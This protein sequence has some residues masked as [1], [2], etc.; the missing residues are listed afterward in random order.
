MVSSDSKNIFLLLFERAGSVSTAPSELLRV[1]GKRLQV[2]VC[3]FEVQELSGVEKVGYGA[4]KSKLHM[5]L[6][7]IVFVW[8]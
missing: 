5:E 3:C 1:A 2:L 4:H 6:P 8:T 7:C